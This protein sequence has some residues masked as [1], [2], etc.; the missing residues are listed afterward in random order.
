MGAWRC[1][2]RRARCSPSPTFDRGRSESLPSGTSQCRDVTDLQVHAAGRQPAHRILLTTCRARYESSRRCISVT[3]LCRGCRLSVQSSALVSHRRRSSRRCRA[4]GP[5]SC[6]RRKRPIFLRKAPHAVD[7][8]GVSAGMNRRRPRSP[9]TSASK[10][11]PASV[12]KRKSGSP[13]FERRH[14]LTKMEV[15]MER[16]IC[17]IKASVRPWPV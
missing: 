4:K 1:R 14:H 5:P 6:G 10:V 11:V 17:R 15:R 3:P 13:I 9:R 2:P 12:R 7:R 16:L 8:R